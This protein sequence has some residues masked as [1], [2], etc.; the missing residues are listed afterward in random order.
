M[1]ES[2]ANIVRNANVRASK[3][4]GHL[5]MRGKTE[6]IWVKGCCKWQKW[7]GIGGREIPIQSAYEV[8]D[9]LAGG[10]RA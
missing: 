2:D 6:G 7:L 3:C 1:C 4:F 9:P 8:K 5:E 10:D